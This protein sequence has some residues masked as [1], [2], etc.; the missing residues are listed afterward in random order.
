M[1]LHVS[2]VLTLQDRFRRHDTVAHEFVD[3]TASAV[4]FV[5]R[6]EAEGS[7]PGKIDP[8]APLFPTQGP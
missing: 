7:D 5:S 6:R 8:V 3:V 4:G 2:A 1:L